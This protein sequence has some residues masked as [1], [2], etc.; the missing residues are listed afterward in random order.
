[1]S[2]GNV[3]MSTLS[4]R[5]RMKS[6]LPLVHTTELR[7][8]GIFKFR[9]VAALPR[10]R[11]FQ[12]PTIL[13]P[14]V[15]TPRKDKIVLYQSGRRIALSSCVLT[16]TCNDRHFGKQLYVTLL[17]NWESVES[18]YSG[19][20]ARYVTLDR[21]RSLL[22]KLGYCPR[23]APCVIKQSSKIQEHENLVIPALASF[24]LFENED[25]NSNQNRS[26]N[27]K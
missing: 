15:G 23:L 6:G 17:K 18:L 24:H 1:M 27:K 7:N 5:K 3:D 25:P 8:H 13:L 21:L 26:A 22:L 19:T 12:G 10:L 2:R 14:R 20:G 11:L 9:K 16:L 4:E